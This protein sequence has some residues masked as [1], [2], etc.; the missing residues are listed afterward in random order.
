MVAAGCHAYHT[1]SPLTCW[2]AK[3]NPGEDPQPLLV[4]AVTVNCLRTLI[5]FNFGYFVH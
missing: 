5:Q 1:L 4:P 3:T 2:N